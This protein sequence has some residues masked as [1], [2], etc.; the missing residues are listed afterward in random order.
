MNY[1]NPVNE[2]KSVNM[3]VCCYMT[4][5]NVILV[6]SQRKCFICNAQK[7]LCYMVSAGLTVIKNNVYK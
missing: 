7:T 2:K 5:R 3:T 4:L 6:V 1:K